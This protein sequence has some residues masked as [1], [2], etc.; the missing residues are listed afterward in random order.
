MLCVRLIHVCICVCVCVYECTYIFTY[1]TSRKCD[2]ISD[3]VSMVLLLSPEIMTW[4]SNYIGYI[5]VFTITYPF[6]KL[7]VS[8]ADI[9]AYWLHGSLSFK[10]IFFRAYTLYEYLPC[11]HRSDSVP[12]FKTVCSKLVLTNGI[13]VLFLSLFEIAQQGPLAFA[14]KERKLHIPQIRMELVWC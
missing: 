10:F 6:S 13:C 9:C 14:F 3:S 1:N 7:D 11:S 5:F 2:I 4:L 8:W 12:H